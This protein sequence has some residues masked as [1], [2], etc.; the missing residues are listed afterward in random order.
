MI[1]LCVYQLDIGAW[2]EIS[3]DDEIWFLCSG[4]YSG[5]GHLQLS[6]FKWAVDS[7][8]SFWDLI[9]FLNLDGG[10]KLESWWLSVGCGVVQNNGLDLGASFPTSLTD[11]QPLQLHV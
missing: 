10:W 4:C 5:C 7:S 6:V 1:S 8:S 3:V 2:L 9:I 11:V